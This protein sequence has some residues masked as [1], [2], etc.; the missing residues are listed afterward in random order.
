MLSARISQLTLGLLFENHTGYTR[1]MQCGKC[2]FSSK[3]TNPFSCK[4]ACKFLKCNKNLNAII[5]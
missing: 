1:L 5:C 2:L 3:Y 4:K